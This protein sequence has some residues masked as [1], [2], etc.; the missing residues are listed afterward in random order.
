ML[1][2]TKTVS[3]KGSI[4]ALQGQSGA[5]ESQRVSTFL[6]LTIQTQVLSSLLFVVSLI[7]NSDMVM[8]KRQYKL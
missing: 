5:Y 2:C 8:L 4:P 1:A 6:L 3:I 7:T